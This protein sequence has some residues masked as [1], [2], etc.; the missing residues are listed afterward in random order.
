KV[1]VV[2][3]RH[4][5]CG[6]M[7]IQKCLDMMEAAGDIILTNNSIHSLISDARIVLTANSGVGLEALI[8]G[9]PVIVSGECDYSYAAHSVKNPEELRNVL[10]RNVVPDSRK[11]L[12][13][14]Y[15]YVHHFTVA[16]NDADGIRFRLNQWLPDFSTKD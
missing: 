2:V 8:H 4:P 1:R 12:E 13:L 5:F 9:K 16:V 15:F 3:K 6:S 10:A 7:T 11:I 14:L